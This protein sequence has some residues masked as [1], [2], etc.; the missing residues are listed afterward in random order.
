MDHADVRRMI[1]AM[2]AQ[3]F[4]VRALC[5]DCALSTDM[6]TATGNSTWS[7]RAA[8]LTPIAKAFG[9]DAGFEVASLGVQVHGGMGFIE[10]TGAAQFLRDVRVTSIYEGTNGIQAMDMVGRKLN[11]GGDAARALIA[12]IS[13]TAETAQ[14]SPLQNAADAL[15][16]ATDWMVAAH[17]N[18]RFA[19]ATSYLRAFALGLGGHYLLKAAKEDATYGPL[20]TFFSAHFLNQVEPLCETAAGG[21]EMLYSLPIEALRS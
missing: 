8:F 4:V 11:D 10:E 7:A 1:L 3:T 5:L 9:T 12:E 15:N 13:A 16:E 20:A 21:A 18:D 17:H 19:G 6:A 14:S 2:K